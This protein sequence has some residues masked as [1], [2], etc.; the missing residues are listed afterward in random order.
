M[1][2]ERCQSLIVMA[3]ATQV[4][5]SCAVLLGILDCVPEKEGHPTYIMKASVG[6]SI[7]V[8]HRLLVRQRH[9]GRDGLAVLETYSDFGLFTHAVHY[10]AEPPQRLGG[11]LMSSARQQEQA[12]KLLDKSL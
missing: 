10:I 11:E 2:L 3:R 9:H 4:E 6:T 8:D 5:F 7:F 12:I 1:V